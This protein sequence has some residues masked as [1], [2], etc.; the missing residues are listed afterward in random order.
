VKPCRL[1]VSTLLRAMDR[2]D[3]QQIFDACGPYGSARRPTFNSQQSI[4]MWWPPAVGGRP[5]QPTGTGGY[6]P[7][8]TY[9]F[10]QQGDHYPIE[11]LSSDLHAREWLPRGRISGNT[12]TYRAPFRLAGR[13]GEDKTPVVDELLRFGNGKCGGRPEEVGGHRNQPRRG[14]T[15]SVTQYGKSIGADH[16]LHFYCMFDGGLGIDTVMLFTELG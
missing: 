4:K 16:A 6:R 15:V 11:T 5:P 3:I 8:S 7:I 1:E 10:L 9:G 12:G 13:N 2:R 14:D